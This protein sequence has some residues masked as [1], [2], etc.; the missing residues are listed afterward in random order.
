MAYTKMIYCKTL[1]VVGHF[2][3]QILLLLGAS[4]FVVLHGLIC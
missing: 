4:A 1:F 2:T 3:S